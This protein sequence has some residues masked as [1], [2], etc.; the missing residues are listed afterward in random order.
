MPLGV[1][2]YFILLFILWLFFSLIIVPTLVLSG[3]DPYGQGGTKGVSGHS[4]CVFNFF[5]VYTAMMLCFH[6]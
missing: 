2:N 3:V 1:T 4:F 5:K 6:W